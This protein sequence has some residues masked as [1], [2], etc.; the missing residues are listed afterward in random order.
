M[1]RD[2]DRNAITVHHLPIFRLL[3]LSS[4]HNSF[5]YLLEELGY[6]PWQI[7]YQLGK[8]SITLFTEIRLS[9]LLIQLSSLSSLQ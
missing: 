1:N 8:L 3:I 5:E 2:S 9:L 4:L 7:L 6:S